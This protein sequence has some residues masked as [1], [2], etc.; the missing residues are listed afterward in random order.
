MVSGR[1]LLECYYF[2]VGID[3]SLL[4]REFT[5]KLRKIVPPEKQAKVFSSFFHA[6]PTT[7]RANTLK[8]SADRLSILLSEKGFKLQL[9]R[10]L[11]DSFILI[12]NKSLKELTAT[13]LYKN[14][15]FYVQSLSSMLPPLIL[16]PKPG[17]TVL[18]LAAAPGSKTTQM[19]ALT[20]NT[21]EITALDS[22]QVRIYKLLASL[23]GQGVKNTKV[24]RTDG[25]FYWRDHR[26]AFN[27]VLLDA[28]CS[29]EGR[30]NV[31]DKDSFSNWSVKNVERMHFL[32]RSLIF[33]AV[34]CLRI[35]GT[36]V[37]STCTLSPEENEAVVDFA[38]T[39]FKSHLAV[40]DI[41]FRLPNFSPPIVS[42]KGTKFNSQI[43]KAVRIF[44]DDKFEGFFICKLRK[45]N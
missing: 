41:D 20:K 7:L 26:E 2:L 45:I 17:D 30:I 44:P 21:G 11:P 28:P 37:Y 35:G 31:E 1:R 5:E 3:L 33:S 16:D 14:G 15:Y 6:K 40:D 18:D 10:S 22:N 23:E 36:L 42:Y 38:L 19:A 9:F 8:I 32:Q 34:N 43:K 27:K 12:G 39:K 13:D 25:R 24:I 4:P 29:G